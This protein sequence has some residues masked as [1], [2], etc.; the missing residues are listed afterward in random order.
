MVRALVVLFAATLIIAA[1][2]YASPSADLYV[3]GSAPDGGTGTIDRPFRTLG[4]AIASGGGKATLHVAAGTYRENVGAAGDHPGKRYVLRGGYRPGSRFAE[5]DAAKFSSVIIAADPKRPVFDVSNADL[6]DIDGFSIQGGSHGIHA[7]GWKSKRSISVAN[8][9]ITKN[10][11]ATNPDNG[12]GAVLQAG[13]VRFLN[14][15][16]EDNQGGKFGAAVM[17][18]HPEA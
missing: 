18:E 8:C 5:R 13:T 16:V 12:A 7:R 3:D 10:G 6:V 2:L 1:R 11:S 17:I 15:R 14:N 4:A 9:V